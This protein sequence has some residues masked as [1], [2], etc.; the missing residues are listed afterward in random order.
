MSD[1]FDYLSKQDNLID[2]L[3]EE[4]NNNN[5][6]KEN[7]S[8]EKRD[9]IEKKEPLEEKTILEENKILDNINKNEKEEKK[10]EN[11]DTQKKLKHIIPSFMMSTF[12]FSVTDKKNIVNINKVKYKQNIEQD[13]KKIELLKTE[14]IENEKSVET[15]ENTLENKND[16]STYNNKEMKIN[17]IEKEKSL[18]QEKINDGW[19]HLDNKD[20][21]DIF[22]IETGEKNKKE[23]T[24]QMSQGEENEEKSDKFLGRKREEQLEQDNQSESEAKKQE[25]QELKLL[26]LVQKYSYG[27]VFNLILRNCLVS[28]E[29]ND[30]DANTIIKNLI[31]EA[32]FQRI[33][34]IILAIGSLLG[35][36]IMF[37]NKN[38]TKQND[39]LGLKEEEQNNIYNIPFMNSSEDNNCINQNIQNEIRTQSQS[40]ENMKTNIDQDF[41]VNRRGDVVLF[42]NNEEKMKELERQREREIERQKTIEEMS[43]NKQNEDMRIIHLD[44]VNENTIQNKLMSIE[45]KDLMQKKEME[46]SYQFSV[47]NHINNINHNNNMNIFSVTPAVKETRKQVRFEVKRPK[48]KYEDDENYNVYED[49]MQQ[50]KSGIKTDDRFVVIDEQGR[51]K[52]GYS[53]GEESEEEEDEY[54]YNNKKRYR[55]PPQRNEIKMRNNPIKLAPT[56]KNLFTITNCQEQ[57]KKQ[58]MQILNSSIRH[59]HHDELADYLNESLKNKKLDKQGFRVETRGRKKK[60]AK[61][62][63][64]TDQGNGWNNF[65]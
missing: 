59:K 34:S 56:Y 21:N 62:E 38:R 55:P 15:S 12:H 42:E 13:K 11:L 47:N 19:K 53:S 2:I 51:L 37:V 9:G 40:N 50:K 64:N 29:E 48:K 16:I 5:L 4:T 25:K 17:E 8:S 1:Y 18:N 60:G 30:I 49:L 45:Q 58:L 14:K 44:K 35:E 52:R 31:K 54:S 65:S 10:N 27:Y 3:K 46:N 7:E 43:N 32:G 33:M 26:E 6:K 22:I 39:I 36:Q 28:E 41:I 63:N 61:I 24:T 57:L 20:D 23:N